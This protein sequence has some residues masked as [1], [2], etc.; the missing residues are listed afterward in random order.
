MKLWYLGGTPTVQTGTGITIPSTF[1]SSIGSVPSSTTVFYQIWAVNEGDSVSIN[2]SFLTPAPDAPVQLALGQSYA[3]I[4]SISLQNCGYT[5]APGDT[6]E[7]SV[8]YGT[9]SGIFTDTIS[10]GL[11]SGSGTP[12][13]N[14]TGLNPNTGYFF[15]LIAK[16]SDNVWSSSS[17]GSRTTLMGTNPSVMVSITDI[18][19]D[20]FNIHVFGESGGYTCMLNAYVYLGDNSAPVWQYNDLPIGAD[21]FN[22]TLMVTGLSSCT[23]YRVKVCVDGNPMGS[24]CPQEYMQTI[25]CSTGVEELV[26]IGNPVVVALDVL[27][28]ELFRG[29]YQEVIA[30]LPV[31]TPFILRGLDGQVLG[32]VMK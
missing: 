19:S 26:G 1:V 12:N 23:N 9:V 3:N 14:I 5:C 16:N 18:A 8:T 25:G 17:V 32:K 4:T 29:P 10:Q 22:D 13:I 7:L 31:N 11:I 6:S 27:G 15:K 21:I 20:G 30:Q 2:G 24:V 28:R